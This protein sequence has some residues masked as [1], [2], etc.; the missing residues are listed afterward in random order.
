VTVPRPRCLPDGFSNPGAVWLDTP[1]REPAPDAFLRLLL[2]RHGANTQAALDEVRSLRLA[3]EFGRAWYV[4]I[5]HALELRAAL[6][7]VPWPY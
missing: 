1:V 7:T 2:A 6:E 3:S 4:R 5:E